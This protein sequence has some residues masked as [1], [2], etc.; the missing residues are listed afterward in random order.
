MAPGPKL[1]AWYYRLVALT[2][3]EDRD[4][5]PEDFDEDLSDID[6]ENP[7]ESGC[8]CDS[9][10]GECD[11][12]DQSHSS[13]R[14]YNGSDADY[15]YELKDERKERKQQ[16]RDYKVKED[17]DKEHWRKWE[18]VRVEEVQAA[19]E[20]L[21]QAEIKG[22]IPSP[23]DSISG[24]HF[25]LYSLDHFDHRYDSLVY[26]T[27]YVE[28]YYIEEGD[29]TVTVKQPPTRETKSE[30]HLYLD[31]A[32]GCDF[33]LFSPPKQAGLEKYSLKDID[34]KFAPIFQFI[35]NDHLIVTVPRDI[36]FMDVPG[37]P[38]APD[39]FTFYGVRH[40]YPEEKR[41]REEE[42]ISQRPP[43]PRDTWF[44]RN[45]PMGAWNMG[46]W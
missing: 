17:K 9:E 5:F 32:C 36:V 6:G 26:P 12:D 34:G 7:S 16:L 28:F 40:D 33:D 18:N 35:S 23:L 20:S 22:H 13:E 39:T 29:D 1:P 2:I 45:H 31:S 44:E 27:K 14:S 25:N 41:R 8:D 11:C 38:S 21:Q 43:S 4:V 10:D 30:G 37:P 3:K 42:I 24:K 15:Y 19:Y 46:G